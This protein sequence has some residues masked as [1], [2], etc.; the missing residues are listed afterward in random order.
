MSG[1]AL[2]V[3]GVVLVAVNGV[4]VAAEFSLLSA[5]AERLDDLAERAR[6]RS[7]TRLLEQRERSL[8]VAQ[9][10]VSTCSVLLGAVVV[11]GGAGPL[12][13]ALGD[14]G[15]SDWAAAAAGVTAVLLVVAAVHLVLGELVPR[16]IAIESPER[17]LVAVAPVQRLASVVLAPSAALARGAARLVTGAT[18][19]V[20]SRFRGARS[21]DHLAA[22]LG[23]SRASG[24]IDEAQHDRLVAALSF[25]GLTVRDVMTPSG[26][27][28][29]V[30]H[31]VTVAQ[32]EE[33]VHRS[34]H[35]R[36]LVVGDRPDEV[37]GFLHV[38]DL[39]ALT[40]AGEDQLLPPGTV[41]VAL[42]VAPGDLLEDVLPRMRRARRHVAVVIEKDGVVGL[43][44]LEDLLEAIVG[45]I[46]DESDGGHPDRKE[47]GTS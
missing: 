32:A 41:R 46:R 33:L 15:M 44:T 27:L 11:A 18:G 19:V 21:T 38:K 45:E 9:A 24:Q 29:T 31:T 34:G 3:L 4:F 43:V 7:A 8:A 14:M 28:V 37:V 26:G 30:P 36:V 2:V 6:V 23:A 22:V 12:R 20:R 1:L 35:S 10:G 16:S 25:R 47:R 40:E 13:S 5:H 39:L 42:R 17:T